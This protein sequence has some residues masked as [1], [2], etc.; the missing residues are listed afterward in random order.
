MD[1]DDSQEND[2]LNMAFVDNDTESTI[3]STGS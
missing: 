3:K 2:E 1:K